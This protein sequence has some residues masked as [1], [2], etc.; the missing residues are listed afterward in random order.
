MNKF[1]F[2]AAIALLLASCGSSH[3]Q[4]DAVEDTI[5]ET[6][7][8]ITIAENSPAITITKDSIGSIWIGQSINEVHEAVEGL[9]TA[10]ENGASED[11]V[12]IVFKGPEGERFIAY[13]FGEG[14][15][16]VLNL[17]DTVVKVDAPRGR[18]GIGDSFS[19]VLELPGVEEEW[20]GYENTGTWYWK[21]EGLWFAPSQESIS[22]SLS[23][24]LYNPV[25]APTRTDF[26]DNVTVGF[27][28][29][30]LPF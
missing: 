21:W 7:T 1:T 10:K 11:A 17:I 23:R 8:E 16:D 3:K 22:D 4:S 24:R 5:A 25:Q 20:S 15:I 2:S 28:G 12:T 27:I 26:D 6:T 19:R 29:T 30:G 14:K 18:F 9:Y 13:D